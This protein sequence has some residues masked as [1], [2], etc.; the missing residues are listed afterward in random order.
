MLKTKTVTLDFDG[1]P[2]TITVARATAL[3]GITRY[4]LMGDG[5]KEQDDMRYIS[6]FIYPN[7]VA[8]TIAVEGMAWP[9]TAQEVAELPE[10]LVTAWSHAVFDCN[11]NWEPRNQPEEDQKKD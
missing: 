7:L 6:M 5:D 2:V 4:R 9:I 8:A 11:P 10:D 1:Q 3:Q